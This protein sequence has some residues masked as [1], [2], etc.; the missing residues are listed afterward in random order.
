MPRSLDGYQALPRNAG[1]VEYR[2]LFRSVDAISCALLCM[3]SLNFEIT[4]SC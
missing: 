4:S 3:V 1:R 2:G